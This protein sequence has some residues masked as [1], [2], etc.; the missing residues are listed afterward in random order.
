MYDVF[1]QRAGR[2]NDT[3]TLDVI[4]TI[5]IYYYYNDDLQ[6]VEIES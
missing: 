2:H 4:I 1:Y 3:M 6:Y 5:I